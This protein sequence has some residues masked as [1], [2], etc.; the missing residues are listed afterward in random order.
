MFQSI[1][2]CFSKLSRRS[3]F[4]FYWLWCAF[5]RMTLWLMLCVRPYFIHYD[6]SFDWELSSFR[7]IISASK[8]F[9][10][11]L[12]P[13]VEKAPR[14]IFS[15]RAGKN[16]I[17]LFNTLSHTHTHT[18][19][20][21]HTLSE[22]HPHRF[23]SLFRYSRRR[24]EREIQREKSRQPCHF[25]HV[26]W[27]RV[28]EREREC[29]HGFS[30]RELPRNSLVE[31]KKKKTK[32]RRPPLSPTHTLSSYVQHS[33]KYENSQWHPWLISVSPWKVSKQRIES[34]TT[35]PSFVVVKKIVILKKWWWR[36]LPIK[37]YYFT[38][39]HT[40]STA[41]RLKTIHSIF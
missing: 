41:A 38:H 15:T 7:E 8:V 6:Q 29:R 18:R 33:K 40:R 35:N 12:W 30:R 16:Y 24:Q 26:E 17:S 3:Y 1:I 27:E 32:K 14:Y 37:F 21:A 23:S 2:V 28:R 25:W 20:N 34:S 39:T 22:K 19:T 5:G 4:S 31:K 11:P 13:S 9:T 36:I 10:L